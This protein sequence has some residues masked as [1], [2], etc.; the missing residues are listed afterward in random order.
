MRTADFEHVRRGVEQNRGIPGGNSRRRFYG[1][2]RGCCLGDT[3]SENALCRLSTCNLCRIIQVPS[4]YA[5]GS[6]WYLVVFVRRARSNLPKRASAQILVDSERASILLRPHQR[7]ACVVYLDESEALISTG[8][9]LLLWERISKQGDASQRC[10]DGE[11]SQAYM[12]R[13]ELKAGTVPGY[14]ETSSFSSLRTSTC[15]ATPWIRCRDWRTW[16]RFEL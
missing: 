1:T 5:T 14:H 6:L 15:L 12:D 11:G 7:S 3:S 8:Q 2:V 16:R 13:H 10:C 4:E 9:R